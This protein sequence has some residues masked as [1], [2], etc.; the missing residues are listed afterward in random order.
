M[1]E[2]NSCGVLIKQ[3][4]GE[5]EKRANNALRSQGLTMSQMAALLEVDKAGGQMPL[6]G[7]ER[8][9]RVAQSTAAGIVSRLEQKGFLESFGSPSDKRVK[10][11][12]ITPLGGQCCRDADRGME[13]TEAQLLAGLTETEKGILLSLLEK[14]HRSL[15]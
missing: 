10:M 13:E 3:V 5:L 4:C 12:R 2:A 11:I 7:L 8:R 14:V 1:A 15:K 6:K 9:L